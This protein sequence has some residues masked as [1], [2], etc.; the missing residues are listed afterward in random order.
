MIFCPSLSYL[1]LSLPPLPPPSVP[2]LSFD[3]LNIHPSPLSRFHSHPFLRR[4]ILTHTILYYPIL[5]HHILSYRMQYYHTIP[6]P[7]LFPHLPIP[8]S[9]SLHST[10]F[11]P[12]APLPSYPPPTNTIALFYRTQSFRLLP[13]PTLSFPIPYPILPYPI[14]SR[15]T[16][17]F[18]S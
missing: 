16:L 9:L 14:L 8:S 10:H 12:F 15:P 7:C 13:Y 6:N 1:E 2:L 17:S 4:P 5:P 18:P 11:L 3:A